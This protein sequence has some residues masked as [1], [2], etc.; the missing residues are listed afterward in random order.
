MQG[1]II[2]RGI[3]FA[4]TWFDGWG[5]MTLRLVCRCQQTAQSAS[6]WRPAH[7]LTRQ[8]PQRSSESWQFFF[9][10]LPQ[11]RGLRDLTVKNEA[12]FFLGSEMWAVV[13]IYRHYNPLLLILFWKKIMKDPVFPRGHKP[14]CQRRKL[15]KADNDNNNLDTDIN[16][17]LSC[18]L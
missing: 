1:K 10:L 17:Y 18:V 11:M 8:L 9:A 12:A 3:L 13:L 16:F 5:F 2:E 6:I 7:L 4:C 14:H 15:S